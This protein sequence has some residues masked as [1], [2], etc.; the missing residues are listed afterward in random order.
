MYNTGQAHQSGSLGQDF[1]WRFKGQHSRIKDW[2]HLYSHKIH[3][4]QNNLCD[5]S[6]SAAPRHQEGLYMCLE[7]LQTAFLWETLCEPQTDLLQ[8]TKVRKA[9]V[10]LQTKKLY[11]YLR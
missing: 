6:H 9:Y 4:L 5:L 8:K 10:K 3:S 2:S 1:S 7:Y 11:Q